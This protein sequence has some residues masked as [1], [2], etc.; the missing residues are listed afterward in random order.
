MTAS[1]STAKATS[2]FSEIAISPLQTTSPNLHSTTSDHTYTVIYENIH[3]CSKRADSRSFSAGQQQHGEDTRSHISFVRDIHISCR[4]HITNRKAVS[5]TTFIAPA[6]QHF[7]VNFTITNLLYESNLG[8]PH[9]ALYNATGKLVLSYINQAVGNGSI[10]QAH[11]TCEVLG[12]RQ[13]R[14]QSDTGV[15]TVCTYRT[16]TTSLPFDR[17]RIYHEISNM[18]NGITTLGPYRLDQD[19]LYVNGYNAAAAALSTSSPTT[20]PTPATEHF[21]LNFSITNLVY[22]SD[23]ENPQSTRYNATGKVLVSLINQVVGN[24]SIGPTHLRCEVKGFRPGRSGSDTVVDAVCAYRPNTSALPFDRVRVYHEISN[25]TNGTSTLGPYRLDR[26][27]LYINGYNAAAAALSTSSPT[28]TPTPATERFT[29]NFSITNLVYQSDLENPQSTRYNATG[30]VLVSLINQVVGNSS[31]GPTH[32]RCEVK[33]FR[34]GRSGSDTVVDAVCT[35][36]PNTSALPFDRV[37]VYHEISNMT[38]GTSTLGPYRLDRDSLYINGYNAAAAALSTSSPTTTPTP[39]TEHFTLNFSI[40]NLVYQSDLENPQSTRYNA[41]GKV[42]V[43][44]INQVVGNSSIGPTHL[45]CEVKGFRPG[46]S[47]SD[48]VV[49][50]VCAYRPNTSALPFD[51]VR[52]YHEISN[53]TNGTSTLGPYRLDRDSL[54]INGY[55]AAAAALSTS[56]PTTTPTPAT[57][58]FTL[59]FSIT[60]LVYQSDLENPQSTR[61]NATGKVLVSLINQVVGNSSIGPTHLRC[62]VKGFRPGRSGSDTVVDAVCTYRPNTSALPFDR[63]RV[64]HEISNMTNGTSTLGPY[65]LDRDSLYIN[66]YNAAAAALSTSSPTTTPTPATEHFTL[67]FSITNL[68]Y[69]SDLENPQSTRYNATGKVLVSLI[70]Q[71]VGNSSIGPTHLRC[72]VKGF[73]PGRSGSDTVVDAV[74]AYRPNTSALPFDRVRVYHEI[75]NMTNGTSTLGP[76]RLDR[77]SLYINGYNAAA[78][79]LSTSSPT[80]TPTPA[81]E[82]F[83][84]N[85]SITNLVYQSD[86]ENPQ[87]TRY[88]AT[89]KVLVSLIN[90]VVGNSSIGPTHLRCEVKGFR[91]GRSGSDT[92]VDAVCAYRPNTSA[93]PFDRVRVYHEIS[94][95]TNGTSTLG[96]YRLDRD[97]LYIN[98]YNA[99]A[100]ALS[101]SSPTTTPTPATERFTLNFSITNLVYQSDLENPQSTRY[102]ATGKV[103]V[104]LIN[105]VVGNSSI[106]PTHLRCEVKGFRPGRSGSDTVVDAVCAY[107]PNTSAL[108]FDRVR[109]YHE[110]SNMT[111]G[112]STLGPY[113][114]DRDSLYINGYNAAAAALSTSSPT[115]TPTP[116]TEHFTLN[117]SI[118]NLV[119]QSDLE[120]PQSTRYNATGK[121]LVSLINQ[122]VGNSSIGPTHLRCEVKGFRPGRSGS[123]TVVDAV[124][125]YRPNTSALPFDRVRIYH[126]ISNMTNGTSTLGPYR[127]DRDSLYING[128]NAAAAA[129]STVTP[130]AQSPLLTENFILN[131][132]LTNLQFTTDLGIPGSPKFNST[133]KIMLHY[134]GPL[135]KN[136]I[137]GPVYT[138]CFVLA[139]RSVNSQGDTGVDVMCSYKINL[140]V[141]TFDRETLY[142]ELSNTTEGITKLGAYTMEKNS[143]YVNGFHPSDLTTTTEPPAMVP[144]E[145]AGY[146]L[147]FRIINANLTNPDPKSSSYQALQKDITDKMNELFRKSDLQGR[148]LFC[149]V[150]GLRYGSIVVDCECFFTPAYNFSQ[151]SVQRAFQAGTKNATEQWLEGNYQLQGTTVNVL[152]PVINPVTQRPISSQ[153]ETF[154]LNFTITNLAYLLDLKQPNSSVHRMHKQKIEKEL[155]NIFRSSSIQKYFTGCSIESFRLIPGKT[156][157]GINAVCKFT[158][159]STSKSFQR[160][161]VYEEFKRLTNGVTQ[162]GNSY[163]LDKD[164]LLVNDYS[165]LNTTTGES[166]RS[167]LPFWAIILI[168]LSALLSFII[169]FLL[170]F[171]AQKATRVEC[172][173]TVSVHSAQLCFGHG[174]LVM[175]CTEASQRAGQYR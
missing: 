73:R 164:S 36:R 150:T 108:P 16:N 69:Q 77:D 26:D 126:E 41:T 59:N 89:G 107:R 90:Q 23:L 122:V 68:V 64:Y 65:R 70:N 57:E 136:S 138:G 88:N 130:A 92:V 140:T 81:T 15:D 162:L 106:G 85:F 12:Y 131:F 60:N 48:T 4:E 113:R 161:E 96:P 45:R 149:N 17:V 2:T 163:S 53:M 46:R 172:G 27:S 43:S 165:P 171:L 62:E 61:Y 7:T 78:A 103:L 76:Y 147:N 168:C 120:N 146:Q 127:L 83:T 51:R 6:T 35:Y 72:E 151:E 30:K 98:G 11:L 154:R 47:G 87:S 152:E 166:R 84:L 105:Q 9:S 5:P 33:G 139:F 115:T 133:E 24:S 97:S 18:T 20:T 82:R 160:E 1:E 91:P 22:Q 142:H 14:S 31:I 167:E 63:V 145:S 170:C 44:L 159:D 134:I 129:L 95:M 123:D 93:L 38:N 79:A 102:N 29:L 28:T 156:Y 153:Q 110:I 118:T 104:S 66:G 100:A 99:A 175:K 132:T 141:A 94:N 128:Y 121:V 144:P 39:A 157:T 135:L 74:C 75:S 174:T 155:E 116:A 40:T 111:N 34:P 19:S 42:L 80:T 125:A 13:G 8:N 119:Y 117:F 21:T 58:R 109:V 173:P 55:N 10:G 86:L 112:T 49:D 148:F 101:T 137:I 143:L 67:N 3:Q 124:C 169:L 54:Y 52:V 25:M 71:V 114:L 37:R 32:L 50:A 56:S 158:L